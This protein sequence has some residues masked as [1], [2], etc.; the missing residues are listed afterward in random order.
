M[1][2]YTA[3]SNFRQDHRQNSVVE[4]RS[5]HRNFSK[6]EVERSIFV[7]E[8]Q[9]RHRSISKSEVTDLIAT[10]PST[11]HGFCAFGPGFVAGRLFFRQWLEALEAIVHFWEQRL[12]G[13]HHL[14]PYFRSKL[15]LP[16]HLCE[17]SERLR[18]LFVAHARGLLDGEAVVRCKKKIDSLQ[19]EIEE[20]SKFLGKA[21]KLMKSFVEQDRK[22]ALVAEQKLLK[23]RLEEFRS[24]MGCILC[25]LQ[26]PKHDN[27]EEGLELLRFEGGELDWDRLHN[28]MARERR[29]LEEGLPIYAH[30][31]EILHHIH[32]QQVLVLIGETGSGKSTQLVQYLV[33]S[34]IAADGSIICTQPRKIAALS[35]AKRV[36]EESDGCYADDS[37]I[38]YPSYSSLQRLTQK[39]IFM[40]DHCLLQHFM[41]DLSL[42]SI[43]CIV[44]D[45]AHER[46]LNTDLLLALTKKLLLQRIDLRLI[47][48]SATADASK[49]SNY[50]FG[51]NTYHVMGRNF[52][53][54]IVYVTNTS[55]ES[56]QAVVSK[57]YTGTCAS[58]VSDAVRMATEILRTEED[59][60]ILVFLTSQ[61]EVEWACEN[62]QDLAAV[63]LA[64]HGK[65]SG[66][67]Q[68]RVFQN[69]PGKRKVIFAT[70]V[71]ET[72]LTIPGVRYVVDSGMVKE[73]RFEPGNGMNVLRVCSISQSSANQRAGRAGRTAAGKCYRLYSEEDF[74]SMPCHLEPEIHKVHLGVAVLRILAVGIKDVQD[75]DFVDAP[76]PDAINMAIRNLIQLGAVVCKGDV[77][78]LTDTGNYLVKLGIEPRLGKLILDSFHYGLCKEGVVLAA[79]MAN[80]S[81]IFCR[82]GTDEE[83]YKS[84]C[85]KVQFCHH[86][87]DLFTLLSVYREWEK[88]QDGRNTW[89]WENSINAKSMRRCR[90]T[91]SELEHCLRHE[92]SM[93][94]PS[95]W[96]WEPNVPTVHDVVLKKVIL[97]SLSENVAMYSGYDKLGYQVASTGQYVQLHPSC[98]L[99]VYGQ[100]PNWVVF[101]ELLSISNQYLVCV[102]A[103][104]YE[105]L[106]S[107]KPAPPF[108]V[109]ELE[110]QKMQ[111]NVITGVGNHVLR[112][113]CG[114]MNYNL[115]CLVSRLQKY[116][117]DNRAGIDVDF[118][119]QEIN[120]FA[121]S[122]CMEKARLTVN[123]AVEYEKKWLRD[124]CTEKCLFR[125]GPGFSPSVALFGAGAEIKHLE[126]DKRHLSVD[127]FHPNAHNLEDKE[128]LIMFDKCTSGIANFHKYAVIGQEGEDS[129]KW[130]KIT[131]LTPEAAAKA[132]AE[133]NAVGLQGALLKVLP[134]RPSFAGDSRTLP[135]PAVRA[136]VSWPRRP[137]RGLAIIRCA[138]E[139][140]DGIVEDCSNLMIG[141]K[142]VHCEIGRKY[143]DCAIISGLDKDVSEPEIVC[144]LRNA[145]KR[146]IMDVHLLRGEPVNQP[147]GGVQ[148]DALLR[149]IAPFMPNK[150]LAGSRCRVQ[151]L[152][153]DSKDYWVKA[154]IMFDGSLH[155]EAAKALQHIE[156]EVLPGCLSWQKIRCQQLFHSSV[157]CP[158]P[159]YLVI[160][161]EL[162][163]LL[164]SFNR[165][166]GVSYSLDQNE[167]GTY[168]VKIS[169]NATKTVAELRK[170]LEQLM[171]GRNLSHP[172]LTVNVIQLLFSR[173]GVALMK[174]LQR[175]TKTYILHDK[176][177]QCVKIFGALRDIAV[178]EQK[179]VQSL[180]ILHE[181]K[182]LEIHLR[183]E[184]LP[185]GLLKEVVLK[186]GPDLHG[187]KEK[188]PGVEF[189]LNTRRHKLIVRGNKELKEKVEEIIL[190][191]AASL[192]GRPAEP[193]IGA[194]TCAICLC[195]VEDCY[196]LE[197]CRHGFC[198]VCLLDQLDSAIKSH[199]GFPVCCAQE[200]CRKPMLLVDLRNLLPADK[201]EDLFRAS[202]GAFVAASGGAYRFCPSPDCPAV[203]QVV[204]PE[205]AAEQPPFACGACF[206]E[207]CRRC[208]LEYHPS[209]T[210][211]RYKEFKDDPDSSLLE[212]RR[213]KDHVKN[214]P[215]CGYTIEKGDGCN[216]IEC[217]CGRHVCWVCLEYFSTSDECYGHLRNIH[218][219][220]I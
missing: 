106:L 20:V 171:K 44:V 205:V 3:V 72:S 88:C 55:E 116:C 47:I 11:V 184:N 16:L 132:V 131:F 152:P 33:D 41:Y 172:R 104:D 137:S 141:G 201:L 26:E 181:K 209:I 197:A 4:L 7:V 210:C 121:S 38:C 36:R 217:R 130:G 66:D 110:D 202:L 115:Q 63:A 157:S 31:K 94:V 218:L 25:H 34:G 79:V 101:G 64:F 142:F 183:G 165:Q 99:L 27:S 73:C 118:E 163:A 138:M 176:Q 160:K 207:T 200:G 81:S 168:L 74:R 71:A 147:S 102:T 189:I 161:K 17:L 128:L 46:S 186:F 196:Q 42:S 13:I 12:R 154:L 135:F 60:A 95:Y 98:S 148:A 185:N 83:K 139:D 51:C 199:D 211:E 133:L 40:T 105:Y 145:T 28:L 203:Y 212:W 68:N 45:E 93:I 77:L 49:L 113:L 174:S 117:N 190:E 192:S 65:L 85:L 158:M 6:S 43:S 30:R 153:P 150:N 111:R 151:M 140:L 214:C 149:L 159:V 75:F 166:K 70:N 92:L 143:M 175:E 2:K 90:D 187:L 56:S 50:F 126:L 67:E 80:A 122:R 18:P 82:V 119:K 52:P 194:V 39:V 58:Y 127:V 182:Q 114:K 144:A 108:D 120:I 100:K 170:P 53:V 180:L 10:C 125:G 156:G 84:D 21:R 69:Y 215:M 15:C 173:D 213:G 48:M 89:C 37:V 35:L 124:E 177:N 179:L 1:R 5:R 134:S 59:G 206:V 208:H 123:D 29:R 155:L 167:N 103:F 86:A 8:L 107:L 136:K 112:R 14:T 193:S 97:S 188:V 169:S 162:D 219:A 78:E 19:D 146:R 24:A 32:G 76:S 22:Q 9:S 129:E 216:H 57:Q 96:K 87:G 220:I 198:R 204:D 62:F 164:E 191:T 91:V 23:R 109:S 61:V 195:E 178:A 54:D